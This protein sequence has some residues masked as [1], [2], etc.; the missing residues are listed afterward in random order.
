MTIRNDASR[1]QIPLKEKRRQRAVVSRQG[2]V[3]L[4]TDFDQQARHQLERIEIE[5]LDMFGMAGR[6]ITP[7]AASGF[8]V[9]APA[10]NFDISVG[11]GYLDGWLLEN[12][13]LCKLAT[14]PHPRTGDAIGTNSIIALKALVRHVDPVEDSALADVA[15]GDAQAS[16]RALNDWQVLPVAA[17]AAVNC[18]NAMA[19]ANWLAMATPSQ[20]RLAFLQQVVAPST[21]P[22][23]LTPSGGYSRLENLLYRIEVHGGAQKFA[24]PDGPRFGLH[25]LKLKLSRR[26]ASLMA[27]IDQIAGAEFTVAPPALDTRHWFAPGSYAEIV[28]IHDDVDPRRALANERLFRV[29]M[30]S[31]D[32]ITLEATAAQIAAIGLPAVGNGTWFLRLWDAFPGSGGAAPAGIATVSAAANAADSAAIDLGDGLSV[33]LSGGADATFRRGDFWTCAVRADGSV[34]WPKTGS[35]A[36]KM[37]PHGPETRYAVLATVANG[38]IEDCRITPAALTDRTLLYR[39]GDGQS[40]PPPSGGG[41]AA[42]PAKLRI[43]VMRGETPVH[44]APVLWELIGPAAAPGQINGA[45]V[46]SLDTSTDAN[47]VSEITWSLNGADLANIH[48]IKASIPGAAGIVP[49]IFSARFETAAAHVGCST[50]VIAEG[51]DWVAI[52]ASIKPGENA[53]ICFQR[54]VFE[55]DEMVTLAEKGHLTLH[56]AGEGTVIRSKKG[57]TALRFEKCDS[58]TV[59]DLRIETGNS[60]GAKKG[61]EQHRNGTLT[62]FD[63]PTVS[64]TDTTLRC[65]SH[66]LTERTCLTVRGS[67]E[68]AMKSAH[69]ARNKLLTGYAQD[70]M[71]VTDCENIVIEHNQIFATLPNAKVSTAKLKNNKQWQAHI[72]RQLVEGPAIA[73]T[74]ASTGKKRVR[75]GTRVLEFES[76]IAQ[77]DWDAFIETNPVDP[78]TVPNVAAAKARMEELVRAIAAEP[79]TMP[80]FKRTMARIVP[81]GT[82]ATSGALPAEVGKAL[83]I[84]SDLVAVGRRGGAQIEAGKAVVAINDVAMEFKT[85]VEARDWSRLQEHLPVERIRTQKDMKR[86]LNVLV[87]RLV[88]DKKFRAQFA[89]VDAWYEAKTKP[90]ERFGRQAITCGGRVLG[91]VAVERNIVHGFVEGVHIGA[92]K[93]MK[94]PQGTENPPVIVTNARIVANELYLQKPFEGYYAP[95]G[96]FLGNMDSGRIERNLLMPGAQSGE[97]RHA[98]GIRVHGHLGQYLMILQNRIA[99]AT[100]G[101][102]VKAENHPGDVDSQYLWLASANLVQGVEPTRVIQAPKWMRYKQRDNQPE[103]QP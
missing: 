77:K 21:D 85:P 4:D 6:L 89:S 95:F 82:I 42:L 62:T 9:I 74:M 46:T 66:V 38:A 100:V 54:G 92:S 40:L 52:L 96:I 67:E 65:G 35:V 102:R 17:A 19:D 8:N 41:T 14:Q 88:G 27:R 26:N 29:A 86:E 44:K 10:N 28:S 101:I 43:A 48:Q 5:T 72:R 20:G 103:P 37:T 11:R 18:A 50:Y 59:R 90:T 55:T 98:H 15:L 68:N 58:V 30:A 31:D 91:D 53:A 51:S 47:G 71:L 7:A 70:G 16:G 2:Q 94:R 33:Q 32:K 23:S 60:G 24:T 13:A 64:I 63:C 81:A 36:D 93:E 12:T 57:E 61:A 1:L 83:L 97:S 78:A 87:G 79:D 22:C 76:A 84:S 34:A 73:E 45:D 3:L 69:I 75:I 56:G 99:I 39:G 80:G 25:G 49:I